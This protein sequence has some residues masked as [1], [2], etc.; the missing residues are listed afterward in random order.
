MSL[1]TSLDAP[2]R[3]LLPILLALILP[4]CASGGMKSS[5]M[6]VFVS[7]ISGYKLALHY[8][9]SGD[10]MLARTAAI[11]TPS[12]RPDYQQARAL[13]RK[14][15]EP[16]RLRLLRHY[17]LSA[18]RAERRGVL[19]IALEGYR[20]AAELSVN[21]HRMQK[22]AERIDLVLRQ[23]RLDRL[24]KQ[25]RLEDEQLLDTLER[26]TPPRGLNPKDKPFE[27]E[28]E[29]AQDRVL[30]GGRNAWNAAKR[31]LH[32]GNP[33]VAYVEAE[34]Y[35]RLRPGSRRGTM[36][37]QEVREAMPKGL[38]IPSMPRS[39]SHRTGTAA[40]RAQPTNVTSEKIHTLMDGGKWIQARDYAIIYRRN[41]GDDADSLL[42]TIDKT[43][44]KQAE[45]AFRRGQ[46]AFQSEQLDKAVAAWSKAVELQPDNNDYVD[47]LRRAQEL[48]ES[49]RVLQSKG[50]N[51]DN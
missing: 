1:R 41:G 10:I 20:K 17:R 36:L 47:S 21:D 35:Q 51:A 33:E 29:R 7:A 32:E 38:H 13:L 43:L 31:E 23:K 28:L 42:Q 19:Y 24:I 34:S 18:I 30:A 44:K 14:K 22:N 5:A 50:N 2:Y 49:F 39:L 27:R 45:A 4:A 8:Y 6:E 46:V 26:Y 12:T 37:M 25:R 9:E 48:Q 15:I 3:L 16:A 11:N 40:G